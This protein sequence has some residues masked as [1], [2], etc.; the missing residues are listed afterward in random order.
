MTTNILGK[1]LWVRVAFFLLLA[2]CMVMPSLAGAV[3]DPGAPLYDTL[4]SWWNQGKLG[5]FIATLGLIGGGIA[6]VFTKRLS[7]FLIPAVGG[8]LLGS[9]FGLAN[10]LLGIGRQIFP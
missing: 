2:V 4:D 9:A 5:I 6:L 1:G 7:Y 8:I 10:F 3:D